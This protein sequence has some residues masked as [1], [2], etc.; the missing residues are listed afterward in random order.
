MDGRRVLQ[1]GDWSTTVTDQ[2][3]I[4]HRSSLM[5]QRIIV[6][7]PG[8]PEFEFR[9]RLRILLQLIILWD[10][11]YDR[12]TAEEDDPGLILV[13]LLGGTDDWG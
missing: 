4:C 6:R 11:T 1:I 2:T 7:E 10:I 13:E 3:E 12:W 9:Y 5:S 8:R